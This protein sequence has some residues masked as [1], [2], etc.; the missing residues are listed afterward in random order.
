MSN[1]AT[2][3]FRNNNRNARRQRRTPAQMEAQITALKRQMKIGAVPMRNMPDPPPYKQTTRYNRIIRLTKTNE[4]TP[5]PWDIT[6]ND[7]QVAMWGTT[8]PTGTSYAIQS[9]RAWSSA[10]QSA[11][12]KLTTVDRP[13][14]SLSTDPLRTYSDEG[15]AGS[16]RP[17][18]GIQY[19]LDVRNYWT[20]TTGDPIAR[21]EAGPSAVMTV[22]INFMFE[23]KAQT[24]VAF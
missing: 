9:I 24:P 4:A 2:P 19:P 8:I 12:I 17:N 14:G 1:L 11:F 3:V 16:T 13:G 18:T 21:I 23:V 7:L 6:L 22:D 15:I 5:A 10:G 20:V